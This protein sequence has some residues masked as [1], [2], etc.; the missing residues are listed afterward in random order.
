[1]LLLLCQTGCETSAVDWTLDRTTKL[2]GGDL[3]EKKAQWLRVA[4]S[5]S[6]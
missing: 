2:L 4:T 6:N 3:L 5:W 1:L